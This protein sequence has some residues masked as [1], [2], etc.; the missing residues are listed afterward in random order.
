MVKGKKWSWAQ[1]CLNPIM[2]TCRYDNIECHHIRQNMRRNSWEKNK[3]SHRLDSCQFVRSHSWK[4]CFNQNLSTFLQC[5][6]EKMGLVHQ[7]IGCTMVTLKADT[8]KDIS[9][10]PLSLT[11]LFFCFYK[12]NPGKG[13][14]SGLFVPKQIPG[15]PEWDLKGEACFLLF[16]VS[17]LR[18]VKMSTSYFNLSYSSHT[19]SFPSRLT[20]QWLGIQQHGYED[21]EKSSI[22]L[23]TVSQCP[24][25]T[26]AFLF[27]EE[28][29]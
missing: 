22:R 16:P 9:P 6:L 24:L 1:K 25:D 8:L 21:L 19:V 15:I 14:G 7:S 17:L 23:A 2:W 27:W 11:N 3:S 13:S 4:C 20:S 18:Q 5:R 10:S 12:N 29:K 26:L 28:R